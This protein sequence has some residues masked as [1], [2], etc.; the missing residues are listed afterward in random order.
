[1]PMLRQGDFGPSKREIVL[2][3][4]RDSSTDYGGEVR[5]KISNI[6]MGIMFWRARRLMLHIR[7]LLP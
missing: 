7:R 1:M 5:L 6:V 2:E 3:L 4:Y